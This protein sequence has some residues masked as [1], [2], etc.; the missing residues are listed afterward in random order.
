MPCAIP[1]AKSLFLVSILC[2]LPFPA[3]ACTLFGAAG[4]SVQDSG[5][6]VAKVRD[7]RPEPQQFVMCRPSGGYAY[8][9]LEAGRHRTLNMGI[10]EKGLFIGRATAGSIPKKERLA[11]P[12]FKSEKGLQTPAWVLEN[13]ASVEEAAASQDAFVE[14]AIY[15]LAD[16]MK[17]AVLEIAPEGKR[18]MRLVTSGTV[19]H[20]NHYVEP[21]TEPFNK[22]F[23]E[24]SGERYQ[25]VHDLLEERQAGGKHRLSLEDFVKIAHDKSAGPDNSIWRTGSKPEGTQTVAFMAVRIPP[26]GNPVI[27]IEWR[28]DP[29]DPNSM[30]TE[31]KTLDFSSEDK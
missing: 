18:T 31:E 9:G 5:T 22:R 29:K 7:W 28:T 15:I 19:F 6:I 10:N 21:E 4:D 8:Y 26:A 24:S 23:G 27:H 14:P 17:T 20:T 1:F 11:M 16:R 2:P 25:R 3:S 12:H 13:C 30:K